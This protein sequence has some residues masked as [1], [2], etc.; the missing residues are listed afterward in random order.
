MGNE[1]K[2]RENGRRKKKE[3][4]GRKKKD[5]KKKQLRGKEN[6]KKGRTTYGRNK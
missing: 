6:P 1:M 5:K 3:K 4:E 2:M